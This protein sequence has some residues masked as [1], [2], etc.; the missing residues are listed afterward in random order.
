MTVV[1]IGANSCTR[2]AAGD[3]LSVD[4]FSIGQKRPVADAASLH[5]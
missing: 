4:A 2:I 1:T 5:H 3:R